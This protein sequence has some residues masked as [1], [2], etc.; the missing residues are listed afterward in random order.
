M[1]RKSSD[2][3]IFANEDSE[4]FLEPPLKPW[5][6]MIVDDEPGVH[7]VTKLALRNVKFSERPLEFVDCYSGAE[8]CEVMERESD[9]ALML[10]DVVMETDDAGLNVARFVRETIGNH[11]VRIVLRTGQPGQAP[12]REVIISFDINDY[13]EKTDLTSSKLFTLIYASLRAYRDITT[14]AASKKGLAH[15]IEASA[16]IFKLN[17]LSCFARGVLEQLSALLQADP[18]AVY[19]KSTT[20]FSALAVR[21][22]E[23]H[24]QVLAGSGSYSDLNSSNVSFIFTKDHTEILDAVIIQRRSVYQNRT[25]AAFF[26]DRNKNINV[27]ILDG[28]NLVAPFE[29][30]LIQIFMRNVSI[31]FE[32]I[33]LQDDLEE[34]QREIVCLLGESVERRSRETG[35]HVRRVAAISE[36]LA[37]ACG[38]SNEEAQILKYASPLHD[39][40]KIAIPDMILNKQ[41]IHT[42]EETVIMREH[43]EIG[44]KMLAKSKRKVLQAAATLAHEHHERW[45][46]KGYPRQLAGKDIHIYGRITAIA[47][48]FDALSNDRCYKRAW[49]IQQVLEL[50]SAER[51]RHFDPSLVDLLFQNLDE[52]KDIQRKYRDVFEDLPSSPP[53]G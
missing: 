14:I 6:I 25:Y 10:L 16:N 23:N 49:P 34:T 9:I 24:W 39:L 17:G 31:A 53:S 48:V 45:D 32:N 43:A 38:L 52:L 29:S 18:G 12:E 41:G 7:D 4:H 2:N 22:E 13:K 50:F 35:N 36:V 40:G 42:P 47:D 3:L 5:R 26:E 28:V 20:D 1:N 33:N 27:L 21:Y 44:Y 19:L 30:D 37:L 46:G 51:G 15:V 11:D 8:A